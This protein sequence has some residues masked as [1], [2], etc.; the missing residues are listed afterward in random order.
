MFW[1]DFVGFLDVFL[2]FLLDFGLIVWGDLF[3]LG[4]RK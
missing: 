4:L 2:L 1:L 3:M